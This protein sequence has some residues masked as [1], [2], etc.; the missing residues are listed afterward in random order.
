M[1]RS[2]LKQLIKETITE[3]GQSDFKTVARDIGL[4]LNMLN[5]ALRTIQSPEQLTQVDGVE[6][7][8]G[9]MYLKLYDPSES[10]G[11]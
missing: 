3:V 8:G 10:I 7:I 2:E 1:T 9:K 4:K 6:E 11:R 5:K